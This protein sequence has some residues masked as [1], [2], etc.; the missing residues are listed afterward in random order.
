[1]KPVQRAFDV[2]VTFFRAR[3]RDSILFQEA[4]CL[5]ITDLH[6][7]RSNFVSQ[8][9]RVWTKSIMWLWHA[10][11]VLE[12]RRHIRASHTGDATRRQSLANGSARALSRY[13]AELRYA[14][15]SVLAA[16]RQD[17]P[18]GQNR[19][20][21]VSSPWHA[22]FIFHWHATPTSLISSTPCKS[23]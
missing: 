4:L 6:A 14:Q 15:A 13:R 2:P 10:T 12:E 1:M 11:W 5:D 18:T 22:P 7:R 9:N 21:N 19:R 16:C 17:G 20:V 8:P 3:P 23:A